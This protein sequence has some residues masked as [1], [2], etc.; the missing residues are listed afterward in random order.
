MLLEH[1]APA[2]DDVEER[3]LERFPVDTEPSVDDLNWIDQ[4]HF[5][6][7]FL[8]HVHLRR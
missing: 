5:V 3:L 6:V 1:E 4:L 2:L 7:D 8:V